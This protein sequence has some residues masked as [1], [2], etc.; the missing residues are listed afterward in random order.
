[1]ANAGVPQVGCA[2]LAFWHFFRLTKFRDEENYAKS[3]THCNTKKYTEIKAR[4]T[5]RT[6]NGEP[7]SIVVLM[8]Q[9]GKNDSGAKRKDDATWYVRRWGAT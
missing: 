9:M 2:G 8:R 1:M 5:D 7:K 4:R 3:F 6:K